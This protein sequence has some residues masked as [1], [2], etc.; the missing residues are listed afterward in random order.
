MPGTRTDYGQMYDHELNPRKGW[1]GDRGS[2]L[3][4][5]LPVKS[6]QTYK[7][8]AGCVGYMDTSNYF[9]LGVNATASNSTCAVPFFA[10]QNQD[11]FDVNPDLG[12]TAGG[13]VMCLCGL[14]DFE[15]E[16]T[17]VASGETFTVGTYLTSTDGTSYGSQGQLKAGTL[18]TDVIV[19]IVSEKGSN[20][21]GTFENEHGQDWVR[22]WTWFMPDTFS[23]ST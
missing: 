20:S 5:A 23:S 19:G 18:G 6:G 10:F 4:K 8:Y 2:V 16:S 12:N 13:T 17:E 3:E 9:V 22:F 11:D 21:D 14:G 1:S 15:L 7:V